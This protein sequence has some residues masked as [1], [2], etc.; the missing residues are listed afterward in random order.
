[1]THII[2]RATKAR[3]AGTSLISTIPWEI[4]KAWNLRVGDQLVNYQIEGVM[5][6][7]PLAYLGMIGEPR[8]VEVLTNFL[9]PLD[10]S[11]K[12]TD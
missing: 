4:R 9:P 10:P 8:L 3:L 2:R 5:L 6:T 7:V 12:C 11:P 1:M